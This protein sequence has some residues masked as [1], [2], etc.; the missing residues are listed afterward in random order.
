[1]LSQLKQNGSV[2]VQLSG[3][4]SLMVATCYMVI[5]LWQVI[6]IF[7]QKSSKCLPFHQPFLHCDH[8]TF[9]QEWGPCSFSLNLGRLVTMVGVMPCGFPG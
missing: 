3:K 9:H 1:M 7:S 2:G 4:D 6:L 8:E 5:N